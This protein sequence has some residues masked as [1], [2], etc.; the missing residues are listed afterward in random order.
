M[1]AFKRYGTLK[2]RRPCHSDSK[3]E[4]STVAASSAGGKPRLT[5]GF[6]EGFLRLRPTVIACASETQ[7][8]VSGPNTQLQSRLSTYLIGYAPFP[9]YE[10]PDLQS[11]KHEL[12]HPS[13]I[14]W[15]R[16]AVEGDSESLESSIFLL[17]S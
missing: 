3:D 5:L 10:K 7:A 8:L 13:L 1:R 15:P 9:Q 4:D 14:R 12:S 6:E 11:L 16:S 2:I 17:V